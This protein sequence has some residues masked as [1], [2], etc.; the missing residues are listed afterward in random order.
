MLERYEVEAFL[1]LAEELHFGRT[2]ERM[3]VSTTRVSQTI[4]KL[5]RSVGADLFT[6][7]SRR[8]ELT[9]IGRQL[10]KDLRPAWNQT[11]SA[12]QRAVEAGRGVTG[13]LR[14]A[15]VN[16]AGGTLL[17][18]AAEL[19]RQ[20]QPDCAVQIRDAQ[21]YEIMP[22]L[23]E[24]EVDIAFFAFPVR[25]EGV[26]VGPALVVEPRLLAVS[27]S[28][29]LAGQEFVSVEELADVEVLRLPETLPKSFRDERT[30][31][32]TPAG[33]S[34]RF[35]P[36]AATFQELLVLI[37]AGR[38]VLPVSMSAAKYYARPEISYIP[39]RDAEPVEWG[40]I[41]RADNTTAR[42]QAFGAAAR[43]LCAAGVLAAQALPGKRQHFR[44]LVC[45]SRN[46]SSNYLWCWGGGFRA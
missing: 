10:E 38:G 46:C 30:P 43:E 41:W 44:S 32:A 11:V 13:T 15:F 2:A 12:F 16:A 27:S 33:R 35:G 45:R 14:V 19:F 1:T 5:E 18:E 37:G 22:W 36:S 31:C 9:P 17:A 40:L 3:R 34:I 7:T 24:N 20:R 6:R 29:P 23:R 25:E 26:V 42:V 4:R 21:L 28:H 39:F 8:V